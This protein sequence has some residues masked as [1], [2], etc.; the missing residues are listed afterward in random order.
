VVIDVLRATSTI[1][2]ALGRGVAVV[3]RAAEAAPLVASGLR[4]DRADTVKA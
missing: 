3:A 4:V 1:A 2:E